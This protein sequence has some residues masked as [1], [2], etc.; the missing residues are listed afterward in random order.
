MVEGRW[1]VRRRVGGWLQSSGS[2]PQT[3]SNPTTAGSSSGGSGAHPAR[4]GLAS[5]A[6]CGSGA[7]STMMSSCSVTHAE[8]IVVDARLGQAAAA[9]AAAGAAG[10]PFFLESSLLRHRGAHLGDHWG[11]VI[12]RGKA[13]RCVGP[14][15]FEHGRHA[16]VGV[17]LRGMGGGGGGS[18][19]RRRRCADLSACPPAGRPTA[20]STRRPLASAAS[21]TEDHPTSTHLPQCHPGQLRHIL[22]LLRRCKMSACTSDGAPAR[23]RPAHPPPGCACPAA[24]PPGCRGSAA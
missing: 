3:H 14:L 10:G 23:G 7:A 17:H 16:D 1:R 22:S 13:E 21:L 19:G 5:S 18:L 20:C 9:A 4:C 11:A 6:P 15:V 8:V 12:E 24:A 2:A